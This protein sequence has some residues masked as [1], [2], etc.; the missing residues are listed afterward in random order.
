[1]LDLKN[2]AEQFIQAHPQSFDADFPGD[3]TAIQAVSATS[4]NRADRERSL[5]A[6]LH[7]YKV[8]RSFTPEISQRIV[9][10][11][12]AFADSREQMALDQNMDL[13]VNEY[14]RLE[15]LIHQ[16]VPLNP[17]SMKPR[18]ITSLTSKAL[19]CCYPADIPILDDYAERALQVLSRICN[20]TPAPDQPRFAAFI[21]V[22]FQVYHEI[23]P[24]LDQSC[25]NG[26]TYKIRIL[27]WLL[28]Y[29]GKPSFD[30]RKP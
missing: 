14:R 21:D 16:V 17:K 2:L 23:E 26:F 30:K 1:M 18:E 4:G 5:L 8:L 9:E 20:L 11:I 29:L 7:G 6:W 25:L 22:W 10:Q 28:W 3:D 27:D 24:V 12:I 13:I 15:E 19:W